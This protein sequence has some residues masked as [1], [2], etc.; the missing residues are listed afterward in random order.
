MHTPKQN[1][2]LTEAQ[3]M[4]E[5]F[6]D[7][8]FLIF[9]PNDFPLFLKPVRVKITSACAL[10]G[11]E[12]SPGTYAYPCHLNPVRLSPYGPGRCHINAAIKRGNAIL[13]SGY[14]AAPI[15]STEQ[16]KKRASR[17]DASRAKALSGITQKLLEGRK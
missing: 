14:H 3:A 9:R 8:C 4:K 11:K 6:L 12:I 7:K 5:E 1:N 10:T 17:V 15:P 13:P 2:D 16:L